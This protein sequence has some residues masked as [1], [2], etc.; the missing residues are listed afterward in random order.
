MDSGIEVTPEGVRESADIKSQKKSSA[1]R[2]TESSNEWN[3][4]EDGV[5][6][7]STDNDS[8]FS[9]I[10][11]RSGKRERC[12][13]FLGLLLAMAAIAG[14]LVAVL[15][16]SKSERSTNVT[17]NTDTDSATAEPTAAPT[18]AT[19]LPDEC[20]PFFNNVDYCLAR[21]L[22]VEDAGACVDCVWAYLPSS[23]GNCPQLENSVCSI[24]NQC[25]CGSCAIYLE[26][27]LDCQST[28][29]FDCQLASRNGGG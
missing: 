17:D 4:E 16:P 1:P 25:G 28:C 20:I 12:I 21:D 19:G 13:M 5:S 10:H 7:Y 24:L 18:T 3:E 14:I 22:S 9:S 23:D 2:W 29:D 6:D 11:N 8:A 15:V 27:Y 26:E